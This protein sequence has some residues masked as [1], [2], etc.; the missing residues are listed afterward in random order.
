MVASEGGDDLHRHRVRLGSVVRAVG[1]EGDPADPLAVPEGQR[2]EP[3]GGM[4]S[5]C[6][7][8]SWISPRL[9]DRRS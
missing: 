2:V 1:E 9:I 3:I 7:Q 4:L 5:G 6:N 8:Y